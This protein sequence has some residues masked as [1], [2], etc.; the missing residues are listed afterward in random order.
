ME[1]KKNNNLKI[2]DLKAG[3]GDKKPVP[4]IEIEVKK[5]IS[6]EFLEECDEQ[7]EEI[8][9][10]L[11]GILI[12]QCDKYEFE[13]VTEDNLEEFSMVITYI[14]NDVITLEDDGFVVKLRKPLTN[15]KGELL[16]E[17]IKVLFERNEDREKTFTKG[18]KV[19]E[20][21]IESRKEYNLAT[22][23]A[24]FE[25][26]DNRMISKKS[27]QKI[28]KTNHRDY[29]LLLSCFSFFRN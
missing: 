1:D 13:A 2:N 11:K 20:K 24:S 14:K 16:T 29:M 17:K 9:H 4:A 7:E 23:A 3:A 19:S 26:V 12:D 15:E 6:D 22:L 25:N 5:S 18:I 27:T 21:N 8:F 10:K 28:Q